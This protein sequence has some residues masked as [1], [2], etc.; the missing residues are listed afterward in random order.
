MP[1]NSINE[2]ASLE[3]LAQQRD[4]A[5]QQAENSQ[6]N[7][8]QIIAEISGAPELEE[9]RVKLIG[10]KTFKL[11]YAAIT[12]STYN[13]AS[14]I[15]EEFQVMGTQGAY[16]YTEVNLPIYMGQEY[17]EDGTIH[18]IATVS[19][20]TVYEKAFDRTAMNVNA[21]EIYRPDMKDDKLDTIWMGEIDATNATSERNEVGYKRKYSELFKLPNV[22]A[23]DM[24]TDNYYQSEGADLFNPNK[25]VITQKTFQFFEETAYAYTKPNGEQV[26]KKIWKDYSDLMLNKNQAIMNDVV[27]IMEGEDEE[28]YLEGQNQVFFMGTWEIAA[29][30]PV[31]EDIKNNYTKWGEI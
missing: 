5:R 19:A 6:K 16:S 27:S 22:I 28:V 3:A 20:D 29:D 18:L 14:D 12:Q 13:T 25:Q 7:T 26:F 8:W 10:Q 24:T 2:N 1:E 21:L 11:N 9:Q 30:L 17:K 31:D 23:G 15:S 4:E